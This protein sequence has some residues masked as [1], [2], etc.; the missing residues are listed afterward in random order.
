PWSL[1]LPSPTPAMDPAPYPTHPRSAT[2]TRVPH[3]S[4][5]DPVL[6]LPS[7]PSL[8]S[9]R[10]PLAASSA[11]PTKDMH[12]PI[13]DTHATD[14][15]AAHHMD[16]DAQPPILLPSIS[17]PLDG[18]LR[19]PHRPPTSGH[20]VAL[21]SRVGI[22]DLSLEDRTRNPAHTR[23]AMGASPSSTLNGRAS[24]FAPSAARVEIE[25]DRGM[26]YASSTSGRGP[27]QQQ[28]PDDTAHTPSSLPYPH[29]HHHAQR[30]YQERHHHQH[31]SPPP[32]PTRADRSR[33]SAAS[34]QAVVDHRRGDPSSS[35]SSNT[36]DRALPSFSIESKNASG[37][38]ALDPNQRPTPSRQPER[39]PGS[40]IQSNPHRRDSAPT[41]AAAP[42]QQRRL[43]WEHAQDR[44]PD[45]YYSDHATTRDGEHGNGRRALH[46]PVRLRPVDHEQHSH[47]SEAQDQDYRQETSRRHHSGSLDEKSRNDEDSLEPAFPPHSS[48]ESRS[49]FLPSHPKSYYTQP[50]LPAASHPYNSTHPYSSPSQQRIQQQPQPSSSH[51]IRPRQSQRVID[52][53]TTQDSSYDSN[54]DDEDSQH[55]S[56]E[57]SSSKDYQFKFGTEMPSTV[58]LSTH[59]SS[60]EPNERATLQNIRKMNTRMLIGL[61][62]AG[63]SGEEAL[64]EDGEEPNRLGKNA[65]QLGQG[66]PS[67]EMVHEFAKAATSIFQLAVRI[68]A[69][70]GKSPEERQVDEEINIIRAK[71]CLL[72][73]STFVVPTVDQ[74]GNVQNDFVQASTSISKSFHE[75]QRELEQQRQP[76]T[77]QNSQKD[78]LSHNHHPPH[79]KY[80]QPQYPSPQDMDRD[81]DDASRDRPMVGY[82]RRSHSSG[83]EAGG[84]GTAQGYDVYSDGRPPMSSQH[85]VR[86]PIDAGRSAFS[87]S[88]LTNSQ[89]HSQA[90]Y[91]DSRSHGQGGHSV[92]NDQHSNSGSI[93]GGSNSRSSKNS[94]VPHQKYRKRAKRT[95]PPGRCLSCDSSDTPEWR[96]G[97]DGARTLCNACGLHY[98]KLL[99]R[100]SKQQQMP[101]HMPSQSSQSSLIGPSPSRSRPSSRSDQLQVITF[102]L[103]RPVSSLSSDPGSETTT[104]QNPNGSGTRQLESPN[105]ALKSPRAA[106]RGLDATGNEDQIM[107]I[108]EET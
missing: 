30:S 67:N 81:M 6:R 20:G 45:Y 96:R 98:A 34:S 15:Y 2:N 32:S 38:H 25:R 39:D 102:P 106:G 97:P 78:K 43:H 63:E 90:N 65:L 88:R 49:Q 70:V 28:H 16:V 62:D 75:R 42:S 55:P 26:E 35:P 14:H 9:L 3:P 95:Q 92:D 73:D 11:A 104:S 87:E 40:H 7:L 57:A 82:S 27:H 44:P 80:D 1:E 51:P 5:R 52:G 89:H 33:Y 29:H 72:M 93:N 69:W 61:H 22:S 31:H 94:D 59:G 86:G 105:G 50:A 85:L 56:F 108:K 83:G 77:S 19:G 24:Y 60:L 68:K 54:I 41:T 23:P 53:S 46:A 18:D 10:D 84:G 91:N 74:H 4:P 58:D 71:R 76:P 107:E 13:S 21:H 47:Y 100:Q 101:Q 79:T 37:P 99:K 103:R 48:R 8:S 64:H 36:R 66:P 12:H 17:A